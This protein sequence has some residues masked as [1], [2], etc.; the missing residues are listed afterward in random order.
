MCVVA[1]LL[2]CHHACDYLTPPSSKPSVFPKVCYLGYGVS[3]V[4]APQI[5][6]CFYR[7]CL[8]NNANQIGKDNKAETQYLKTLEIQRQ[9]TLI[10]HK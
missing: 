1:L 7:F 5:K 3:N 2:L 4:Q 10:L 9:E 6:D 8:D